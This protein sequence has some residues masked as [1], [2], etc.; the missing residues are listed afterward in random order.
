VNGHGFSKAQRLLKPEA[1]QQVFKQHQRL[2]FPPLVFL[3]RVQ[4]DMQA[5]CR[6][7]FAVSKKGL[8]L[9]VD[10]NQ[11]KRL[12]REDFRLRPWPSGDWVVT[13]SRGR[14]S[15]SPALVKKSLL[16]FHHTAS[17]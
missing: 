15:F 17:V 1:F 16:A 7:G 11:V 8:P 5:G 3:R 2:V 4:S 13:L 14:L 6:L 10:R 9:A 12:V